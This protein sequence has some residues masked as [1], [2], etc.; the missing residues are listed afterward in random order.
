MTE[1]QFKSL[2]QVKFPKLTIINVNSEKT[3]F[4]YQ[5]YHDMQGLHHYIENK[6]PNGPRPDNNSALLQINC[7][8]NKLVAPHV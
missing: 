5:N 7:L 8:T 4:A 3:M 6:I 2:T 1:S